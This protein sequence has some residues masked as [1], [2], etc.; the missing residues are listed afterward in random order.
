VPNKVVLKLQ[1][2]K[3][4]K[5]FRDPTAIQFY[6]MQINENVVSGL[7]PVSDYLVVKLAALSLQAKYGDFNPSVHKVGFF[8]QLG[9]SIADFLPPY[10]LQKYKLEYWEKRLFLQ[11][12]KYLGMQD[13]NARLEY[14]RV[15][16]K[17]PSFGATLFEVLS[18]AHALVGAAEDGIL[19]SRLKNSKCG[20]WVFYPFEK[21]TSFKK[22]GFGLDISV[23]DANRQPVVI[24]VGL[25]DGVVDAAFDCISDYYA[26]FKMRVDPNFQL[27]QDR[28]LPPLDA[29]EDIMKRT[30]L[31]DFP[32]RLEL[33]KE[34]YVKACNE[35]SAQ[36]VPSVLE[37]VDLCLDLGR[38]CEVLNLN[39]LN[40][41][42][43]TWNCIKAALNETFAFKPMGPQ[44][45]VEN[46][47]C[48]TLKMSANPKLGSDSFQ[49]L[50]P[51][52]T[53]GFPVTDL[54]VSNNGLEDEKSANVLGEII[55][56]CRT[57]HTLRA[58][59]NKFG[60]KPGLAILKSLKENLGFRVLDV[61]GCDLKDLFCFPLAL[62]LS[63][64]PTL[65]ELDLSDNPI[66]D[67]G[68]EKMLDGLKRTKT[69]VKLHLTNT[70]VKSHSVKPLL[71]VVSQ[72]KYPNHL[73]LAHTK[74]S[75]KTAERLATILGQRGPAGAIKVLD[76]QNCQFSKKAMFTIFQSLETNQSLEALYCGGNEFDRLALSVFG[77]GI[78]T[79][80]TLK[81]FS[82]QACN[83]GLEGYIEFANGIRGNSALTELD[84][85]RNSMGPLEIKKISDAVIFNRTLISINISYNAK[86]TLDG[87]G[88]FMAPFLN[89]SNMILSKV[90]MDGCAIGDDGAKRVSV[91]LFHFLKNF[92]TKALILLFFSD[93]RYAGQEF[94][95]REALAK[96]ERNHQRG[97]H[98]PL[99]RVAG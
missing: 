85:S 86:I 81:T 4:P 6:W 55:S 39:S 33:F 2:I 53:A 47:N 1:F 12:S 52:I 57:I 83:V 91:Y 97:R 41:D 10:H 26:L 63:Q 48:K 23:F 24:K 46:F 19:L 59:G 29:Y 61:T 89:N 27:P 70:K 84:L 72:T 18:G 43:D 87:V 96:G 90:Y 73:Y 25:Q 54:D 17:S 34:F 44:I 5:V 68:L 42:N 64:H 51:I 30:M 98:P 35:C 82:M 93:W 94:F 80:V 45:F 49:S 9:N 15:A 99:Q 36:P 66:G 71:D 31:A 78:R 16:K 14:I 38:D 69:L 67:E 62:V 21:V 11:H 20:D 37:Q 74:L 79:N 77:K 7:Y 60:A 13:V 3:T 8:A 95:D 28:F 75:D 65:Q 56:S 76:V 32:S 58:A 22:N 92:L 40:L 88:A 50:I